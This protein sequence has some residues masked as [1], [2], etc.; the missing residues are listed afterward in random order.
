VVHADRVAV[1]ALSVS[2]ALCS[3]VAC[4]YTNSWVLCCIIESI[5]FPSGT[6]SNTVKIMVNSH[7]SSKSTE[8]KARDHKV[9]LLLS[10]LSN[11]HA[12]LYTS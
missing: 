8:M 2:V 3:G 4:E 7:D 5:F 9:G 10:P 11:C 12:V 1:S 6:M